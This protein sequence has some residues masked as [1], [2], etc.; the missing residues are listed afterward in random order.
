MSS[1]R[2]PPKETETSVQGIWSGMD[3]SLVEFVSPASERG[4]LLM[5]RDAMPFMPNTQAD[6]HLAAARLMVR[7]RTERGPRQLQRGLRA[8]RGEN[9]D[10]P[11][12]SELKAKDTDLSYTR[13]DFGSANATTSRSAEFYAC[14]AC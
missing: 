14:R 4:Y 11:T 2:S 13:C 7:R 3:K 9:P 12:R 8:L 5:L 1:R 10:G 6:P